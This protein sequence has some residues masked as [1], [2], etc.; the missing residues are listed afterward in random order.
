MIVYAHFIRLRFLGRGRLSPPPAVYHR[1]HA[2]L[3]AP[4]RFLSV[5]PGEQKSVV[6]GVVMTQ[7]RLHRNANRLA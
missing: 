2:R 6:V 3:D 1:V 4:A 5:N 7:V